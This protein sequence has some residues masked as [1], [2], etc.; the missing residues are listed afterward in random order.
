MNRL[1]WKNL[2]NKA[3]EE[4]ARRHGQVYSVEWVTNDT[5]AVE[6]A[7]DDSSTRKFYYDPFGQIE[8]VNAIGEPKYLGSVEDKSVRE[9]FLMMYQANKGILINGLPYLHAWAFARQLS[10]IAHLDKAEADKEWVKI[11][12]FRDMVAGQR[13][14]SSDNT[15]NE[16]QN[17]LIAQLVLGYDPNKQYSSSKQTPY[18]ESTIPFC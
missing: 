17:R 11:D 5:K 9:F 15:D 2:N 6:M 8:S 1:W 18:E 13:G 16:T 12:K 14:V 10:A 4:Y 3:F 7:T